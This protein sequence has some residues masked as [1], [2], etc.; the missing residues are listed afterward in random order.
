MILMIR[1]RYLVC[2]PIILLLSALLPV[3][4]A[5]PSFEESF[6]ELPVSRTSNIHPFLITSEKEYDKLCEKAQT[7]PWKSMLDGAKS[8]IETIKFDTAGKAY[9]PERCNALSD[10]LSAYSL[11]YITDSQNRAEY[12]EKI[13]YYMGFWQES[14]EN[15]L[16]D[17]LY[18]KDGDWAYVV[19]PS[20]ALVNSILALDIVYNSLT[21]TERKAYEN[22]IDKAAEKFETPDGHMIALYGVR[23]LWAAYKG[24]N[25]KLSE[26]WKKTIELYDKTYITDSGVGV[27]SMEYSANR[28]AREH[29]D[30]KIILPVV[31]SYTGYDRSFERY[32]KNKLFAQWLTG[33]LYTPVGS[34]WTIGDTG[35]LK[36]ADISENIF[37]ARAG[38]Y[39][40]KASGQGMW[41]MR[42]TQ[43]KGRL[44]SYLCMKEAPSEAQKPESRIFA[45]GGAWFYEDIEKTDSLAGLLWNVSK[46]DGHAHKEVNSALTAGFGEI[47]TADSGYNG[48]GQG[49]GEYTWQYINNR[50]VSSNTVLV[51]YD[52][53]SA[54][55]PSAVNDHKSKSGN[56]IVRGITVGGFGFAAGNS[57]TAISNAVHERDFAMIGSEE[58]FP[59][60]FVLLDKIKSDKQ[61]RKITV[62]HRPMSNS[63]AKTEN[64]Y[65]FD[66]E[67]RFNTQDR[68]VRLGIFTAKE[69]ES[70]EIIDGVVSDWGITAQIKPLLQNYSTEADGTAGILNILYPYDSTCSAA[71]AERIAADNAD[72]IKLTAKNGTDIILRRNSGG[73]I[74]SGGI[75]ADADM[76]IYRNKGGVQWYFADNAKS[77]YTEQYRITADSLSSWYMRGNTGS[78]YAGKIMNVSAEGAASISVDGETVMPDANGICSFSVA[79]GQHDIEINDNVFISAYC[80]LKK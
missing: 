51:D 54:F 15:N 62:V 20:S 31:M 33:Y 21:Y 7:E 5:I 37:P 48:W 40:E 4:A 68:N 43:L 55:N 78:F 9:Y 14:T 76:L 67:K 19:P 2:V 10:L 32:D 73:D 52:Y 47:L 11:L 74:V 79:K 64:G 66:I 1:K 28:F 58:E 3:K 72:G 56:G 36:K 24:D 71:E 41:L 60:Y 18:S 69:P 77:I 59:G 57:G 27:C 39:S 35:G 17:G 34:Y 46:E 50:A 65:V 12:T 63:F 13:K 25:E 30:S 23:G 70:T 75:N 80:G 26:N 38:M 42:D 61:G 49:N 22:A 6:D 8:D 16:Y 53:S 44:L 45:D 29:R